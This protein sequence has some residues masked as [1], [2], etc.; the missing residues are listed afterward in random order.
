[1]G[2]SVSFEREGGK[3]CVKRAG[4]NDDKKKLQ[5][6]YKS[7]MS[8]VKRTNNQF[9]CRRNQLKWT[10][11]VDVIYRT[12]SRHDSSLATQF[13]LYF[14][15]FFCTFF[16]I[17]L[18]FFL[19]FFFFSKWMFRNKERGEEDH[20]RRSMWVPFHQHVWARWTTKWKWGRASIANG[21]INQDVFSQLNRV[22]IGC[23]KIDYLVGV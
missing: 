4:K 16:F 1:M 7:I 9:S 6:H 21:N 3:R 17:H 23:P 19:F 5:C 13:P 8:A 11:S 2:V 22:S 12:T 15:A 18:V 20:L 14:R 10:S